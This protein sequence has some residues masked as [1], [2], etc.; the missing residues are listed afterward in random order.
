MK[1]S[2][3]TCAAPLYMRFPHKEAAKIEIS[4]LRLPHGKN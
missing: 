3:P 1:G 4:T 2:R